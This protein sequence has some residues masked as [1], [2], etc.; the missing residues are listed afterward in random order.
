MTAPIYEFDR[1]HKTSLNLFKR[2][3]VGKLM[4]QNKPG[5]SAISDLST[6]SYPNCR[7][8]SVFGVGLMEAS[9]FKTLKQGNQGVEEYT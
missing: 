3:G 2:N 4:T 1:L 9:S 7:L 5:S 8:G 6:W